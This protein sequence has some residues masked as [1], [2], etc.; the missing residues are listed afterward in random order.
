M[1]RSLYTRLTRWCGAIG[2]FVILSLSAQAQ[3][4][5]NVSAKLTDGTG[6]VFRQGFLHFQLQNCGSN[7]PTVPGSPL[8][9]VQTSF[10][11]HSSQVDGT[12]LGKVIGNDVISCGNVHSTFYVV[13]AMKDAVTPLAPIGGIKYF[14][15]SPGAPSQAQCANPGGTT[16]NPATA[17][18]MT[19]TPVP[20]GFTLLYANP[21]NSQMWIQPGGTTAVFIGT[22]DFSQA[23][24]IGVGGGGGGGGS[25]QNISVNGIPLGSSVIANFNNGAPAAQGGFLN[26]QFQFDASGHISLECPQGNTAQSFA[27]GS[28]STIYVAKAGDTMTGQ[29]LLSLDPTQGTSAV[30]L[31]YL[32]T[33]LALKA[34]LVGGLVPTSQLG[35]GTA[36]ST[37]VLAGN[38]TWIPLTSSGGFPFSINGSSQ[39]NAN[40]NN[41]TPA[42]QTGFINCNWQRDG[43]GNVS[44][45]CP[46]GT[47]ASSFA[48]GDLAAQFDALGNLVVP[49]QLQAQTIATTAA[50][51]WNV[52]G[53]FSTMAPAGAS[54]SRLGFGTN[55]V[56]SVSEN[57][58]A[59]FQVEKLDV[60]GNTQHNAITATA[61]V[62]A[63]SVCGSGQS[64]QGVDASGNALGC[65]NNSAGSVSLT[66]I[67]DQTLLG[68]HNLINDAQG[69]FVTADSS[70][71]DATLTQGMS[72]ANTGQGGLFY[73]HPGGSINTSLRFNLNGAITLNPAS[74]GASDGSKGVVINNSGLFLAGH[75]DDG[76]ALNVSAGNVLIQGG[77][78]ATGN[79]LLVLGSTG[80][81][82]VIKALPQLGGGSY[83]LRFPTTGSNL[84]F[85][86]PSVSGNLFSN[87]STQ[88]LDFATDNTNDIG[89]VSSSRPRR[90]YV[91]TDFVGPIGQTT[92]LAGKFSS[93]TIST[94]TGLVQ[95]A[96]FSST[97]VLSGTGSDCGSGGGGG[98]V[99][100]VSGT[101]N[102][103]DVASGGTTPVI[104]IDSTFTFPGTVTNDLSIFGATTSAQLR[105][106]LSDETGT[107][108]A[109]FATSPTLVTP[110]LGVASATS[111]NKIVLTAPTTAATVIFGTDNATITFQGTDTYIGR[112]TTDTLTHKTFDTA[113]TGNSFSIAS[114]AVTANTGT[115]AVARATSPTFVTPT[116]G[117]AVGTSLALGGGTALTTTN[118]TGTGSLVLA[119]SPTLVTPILGVA[120]VTTVNKVTITQP[121]SGSTLTIADG[122]VFA[123]SNTLTFT[124]TDTSSVAFGA[125]GTVAYTS[126][127]LSV[128]AS[129]TSAQLL[130]VLSD[131]TG[132]G[133][134][135]FNNSPTILTPTIASFINAT[136]NHQ[137][138][139]GGGLLDASVISTGIV[140]VARLGTG[141]TDG[142]TFLRSDGTWAVA[143][144]PV[145]FFSGT[146]DFPSIVDGGCNDQTF[147]ATG[148]T[149]VI[150]PGWPSALPSG[151]IGDMWVSAVN[152]IKVRL[153]NF[154]GSAVDPASLTY[155]ASLTT[156]TIT[157][158]G[159]M[160]FSPIADG[161]CLAGTFPLTGVTAGDSI[162]PGWPSALNAGLVGSMTASATDTVNVTLCNFSGASIDPASMTFK[163]S[164]AK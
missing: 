48:R 159:V 143:S 124:G 94:I 53:A 27:P 41:G 20:P 90:V 152:T 149:D 120:T 108:V 157:G 86:M 125:G 25:G 15:C 156:Y 5:A 138:S 47:S 80:V 89:F 93:V 10:D 38:N 144:A 153:C 150:S 81:E 126:N 109:V 151:L 29:L 62:A 13:T 101:A 61:F 45:E 140:A 127:N 110:T 161:V 23:T 121:A 31:S 122:K 106:V 63:P 162:V 42:A 49:N 83:T 88:D 64:P 100:S 40:L 18:P 85:N 14:I 148:V 160:D 39:N 111:I 8:T 52:L 146:I 92:P 72:L 115:G 73:S 163:A 33:Q 12:I 59:V 36:N 107:G 6:S 137:T 57:G 103:V 68:G 71:T 69:G 91:A 139:A 75:Y 54:Q 30:R 145:S 114:V 4:T 76:F 119:T 46:W 26:C 134:A 3:I 35:T 128:F 58:G 78:M 96:H 164:V 136:H 32:N 11:M 44:L 28:G 22:F 155:K 141:T 19:V 117:A 133:L 131:E 16:F 142:T 2:V 158:S 56:L 113:G 17:Q 95:C 79:P 21:I 65:A 24:V 74:A 70:N 7:F 66:P 154:S 9:V 60:N 84:S 51:G 55:G 37:T 129:T 82:G 135:V 98:S 1:L 50:G 116:L 97:G 67:A 130:G 118:Q 34:S 87:P 132:T 77:S 102:Q 105:G 104:S 112:A 147:T 99:T 43:N 123:V